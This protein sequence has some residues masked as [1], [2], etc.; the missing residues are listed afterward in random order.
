MGVSAQAARRTHD[1]VHDTVKRVV[2]VEQC[3]SMTRPYWSTSERPGS[4]AS[5]TARPASMRSARVLETRSGTGKLFQVMV[6]DRL[7][8]NFI[9]PPTARIHTMNIAELASAK[10]SPPSSGTP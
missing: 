5:S 9:R 1:L 4:L 2:G 10:S 3:L 8:S 7:R 6:L